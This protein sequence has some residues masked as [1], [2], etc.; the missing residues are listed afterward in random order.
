MLKGLIIIVISILIA[1]V[2]GK[3]VQKVKLPA[4]LF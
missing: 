1:T 2:V 3:L 4:I